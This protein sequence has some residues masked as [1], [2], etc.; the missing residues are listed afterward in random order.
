MR[1]RRRSRM[2]K[3]ELRSVTTFAVTIGASEAA[4]LIAS[5]TPKLE[6]TRRCRVAGHAVFN[7]LRASG[8]AAA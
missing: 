5:P 7:G 6:R 3:A 8:L 2:I 4:M 1:P